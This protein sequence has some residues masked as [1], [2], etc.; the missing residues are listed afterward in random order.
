MFV[1]SERCKALRDDAV[2]KKTF[3]SKICAQHAF[4]SKWGKVNLD[5]SLSNITLS[6]AGTASVMRSAA[7]VIAEGELIVGYNFGD[8]EHS[9]LT[10]DKDRDTGIFRRNG[11]SDEQ[12]EWYFDPEN[13]VKGHTWLAP[14]ENLTEKERRLM[15]EMTAMNSA[16]SSSITANH[17]VIGYEK[18]LKTAFRTS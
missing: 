9:G 6:A 1:L 2:N 17:S 16:G 15:A 12:I 13:Q 8:G 11:F 14:A 5:P 10:G 3:A 4:W 7:P 18:V